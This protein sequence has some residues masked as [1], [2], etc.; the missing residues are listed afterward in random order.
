MNKAYDTRL[1]KLTSWGHNGGK[2][3][4]MVSYSWTYE[5]SE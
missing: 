1:K 2:E 4:N 5:R 3:H